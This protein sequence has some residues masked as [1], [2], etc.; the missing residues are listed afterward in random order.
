MMCKCIMVKIRGKQ[1][2]PKLSKNCKFTANRGKFKNLLE[3]GG[4]CMHHWL[5]GG[6][7]PLERGKR[8]RAQTGKQTDAVHTREIQTGRGRAVLGYNGSR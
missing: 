7:T 3:L 5:G 6:R 8:L 2:K 4:I 1:K